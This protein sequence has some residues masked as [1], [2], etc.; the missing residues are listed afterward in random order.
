MCAII[1]FESDNVTEQDLQVLKRAMLASR[2]RGKHASG[3]AWVDG[4]KIKWEKQ[5][6][7]MDRF[8]KEFDLNKIVNAGKVR[9]IAHAR[10]ST[11]D[12]EYNQ[13]IISEDGEMA[14]AHNGV[15][16]QEPPENW[17]KLFGY[18]CMTKNDSELLLQAMKHGDIIMD[19]FPSASIA[20]LILTKTG[21]FSLRNSKRPLWKAE[22]GAG[23]IYTSTCDILGRA[24][25]QGVITKL[26][27]VDGKELQKRHAH[28]IR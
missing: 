4:D 11:S 2:I 19:K 8:L 1:G 15:V 18:K 10:Y 22:L 6:W 20:M 25:V 12:L 16:T 27:S 7:P 24:G 23:T 5:P 3:V 14:I 28:E 21:L 9:M 13:P 26:E 17:E